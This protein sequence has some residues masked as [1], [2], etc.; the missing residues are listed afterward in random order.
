MRH[1]PK[2]TVLALAAL[3]VIPI[4]IIIPFS[5]A[6]PTAVPQDDAKLTNDIALLP[7]T[8]QG[9]RDDNITDPAIGL[10][11]D[12]V[13]AVDETL[14]IV[15]NEAV[16]LVGL[17]FTREEIDIILALDISK[18]DIGVLG[19][20][21]GKGRVEV[22][23]NV[24]LKLEIRVLCVERI[25]KLMSGEDWYNMSEN[26]SWAEKIYLP[27]DVYRA[28]LMTPLLNAFAH[29]EEVAVAQWIEES[30]PG[31]VV[32]NVV[33]KWENL[34]II[35]VLIGDP[36]PREPPITLNAAA[37][38]HYS[39][40]ILLSDLLSESGGINPLGEDKGL[41]DEMMGGGSSA[42]GFFGSMAYEQILLIPMQP[43]WAFRTDITL[44]KGYTFEYFNKWNVAK[45]ERL[46][47]QINNKDSDHPLTEGYLASVTNR[48]LVIA[49]ATTF[50]VVILGFFVGIPSAV[51]YATRK[52]QGKVDGKD[53]KKN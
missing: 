34:T 35:D 19:I 47:I 16:S 14:T 3:F 15:A 8:T 11:K 6:A 41:L 4:L 17:N 13:G 40:P 52:K 27:A 43:G 36:D 20:P 25:K 12:A 39:C 42:K 28:T 21:V 26:A 9:G 50:I 5:G 7:T 1:S 10:V 38:I 51:A 44:P 31:A 49:L 30:L 48:A 24:I 2:I 32:S 22:D 18:I 29:D 37:Q 53:K 33:F 23:L 46:S 45:S